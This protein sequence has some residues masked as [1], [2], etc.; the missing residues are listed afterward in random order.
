MPLSSEPGKKTIIVH[1][2]LLGAWNENSHDLWI[3]IMF[4]TA[5]V[6]G[7]WACKMKV[8]KPNA[9]Y[10]KEQDINKKLR[11]SGH[12]VKSKRVLLSFVFI[13]PYNQH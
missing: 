10:R 5:T 4:R 11:R 12:T 1:K 3:A 8:Y 2:I 13:K 6:I 7:S 9:K